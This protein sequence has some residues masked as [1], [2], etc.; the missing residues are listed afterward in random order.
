MDNGV[1]ASRTDAMEL[2]KVMTIPDVAFGSPIYKRW[3]LY[4]FYRQ[5]RASKKSI[6]GSEFIQK[7]ESFRGTE[8]IF[9]S[10]ENYKYKSE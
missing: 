3:T 5:R 9:Q 6:L 7:A 1:D 2:M 4:C 10:P 8:Q